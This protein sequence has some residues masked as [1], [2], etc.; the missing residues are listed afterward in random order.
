KLI[1]TAVGLTL[2]TFRM[3]RRSINSP[4]KCGRR[5]TAG[6]RGALALLAPSMLRRRR[7]VIRGVIRDEMAT[8]QHVEM[9]GVFI[10]AATAGDGLGRARHYLAHRPGVL[11]NKPPRPNW[12]HMG[13]G[14]GGGVK[15]R[16]GRTLVGAVV[17]FTHN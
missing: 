8:A 3:S 10:A 17:R 6:A 2:P 7:L 16:S 15:F 5:C 13:R 12:A 1:V 4:P 11:L 9:F 14:R